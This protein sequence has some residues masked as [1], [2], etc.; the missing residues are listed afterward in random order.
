MECYGDEIYRHCRQVMGNDALAADV[1][2][3]VFVQAFRD[4]ARFGG[5]SSFRTWLYAIAR[6]RCLD[7]LKVQ[8]RRRWRFLQGVD[9][10]DRPDTRPS[11]PTRLESH[12]ESQAMDAA[13]DSL[14]P[15]IRI[16]VLL[17]YR[18]E[19]SYEEM[20]EVCGE[21]AATL[22]ARVQRALPKLKEALQKSGGKR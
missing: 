7:A 19:M 4:L 10:S 5:R 18:E 17:R 15:E 12:S 14:K 20:A 13:L 6:N 8:K 16:A 9:T 21:K 2:Q 11:A 3:T 22:Q 1:H